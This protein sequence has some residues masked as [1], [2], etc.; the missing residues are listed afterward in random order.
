MHSH[1]SALS[2]KPSINIEDLLLV[3]REEVKKVEKK[4]DE[5][6]EGGE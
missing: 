4:C 1:P 2:A 5:V 6:F 3:F